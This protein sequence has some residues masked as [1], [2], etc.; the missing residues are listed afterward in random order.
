MQAKVFQAATILL[1][2]ILIVAAQFAIPTIF[3]ADGY[4][5]IRMAQLMRDDGVIRDF[6]WAR[7]ST[8]AEHFSDK[9]F[10]Y[11]LILIPF[12]F[13]ADIF[14]GAKVAAAL[15][16]LVLFLAFAY[17]L[18]RYCSVQA[19]VPF[20]LVMFLCSSH[21]LQAINRPRNMVFI[22]ALSLL[23]V[24][25]LI[26]KK[27]L[28]LCLIAVVYTLSH[29]SGPF[30]FVI[31]LAAETVRFIY[32]RQFFWK[33]LRA[34]AFGILLGLLIH[35]NFP[36]NIL[37]FYLNGILV[38]LYSFKWGLELGAEF[39]PADTRSLVLGYPA[40]WVSL[41]LFIALGMS[42]GNKMGIATRI[43]MCVAGLFFALS[44]FSQ[45][46]IIHSYPM[47]LVAGASYISDWWASGVR[48]GA[49]RQ[50]RNLRNI[51]LG[52]AAGLVLFTGFYVYR[53]FR[54]DAFRIKEYNQHYE[55]AAGWIS[56]YVPK[57][58]IV[59]HANWSDSQY[60][61]GL[62]PEYIYFVTLDPIYMYYW[63][64][65]KYNLYRDIAFGRAKDPYVLLKDEFASWY[66]YVGK[67]YFSGLIQQI[68][69]DQ[70]FKI[71]A[72]DRLGLLFRLMPG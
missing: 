21:F 22:I 60:F 39:F 37:V 72:E 31:A 48:L 7:Y 14:F 6:D 27:Q 42:K 13:F 68:R 66:G 33:S 4:L 30:L 56:K 17:M 23:F 10:L 49:V 52:V 59:F 70:R 64:P 16:A 2:V 8:F 29:V 62:A 11:H 57:G 55:R 61:I 46:Y 38:P 51:M 25:F 36:N 18:R 44:L 50:N 26:Q 34:V 19:L 71:L 12:T 15:F 41:F 47:I 67:N 53:D 54:S 1:C 28:F 20:F 35:P 65:R 5:H 58:E 24:H 32:N 3:G 45:R 63:N 43:W 69:A 9:D 40:V